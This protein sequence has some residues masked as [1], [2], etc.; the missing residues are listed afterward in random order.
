MAQPPAPVVL[1]GHICLWNGCHSTFSSLEELISHVNTSHLRAYSSL[2]EPVLAPSS[3][4]RLSSDVLGLS[5][6]WDNCHEYSSTPV[7]S[8]VNLALDDALNSLTG[9]LLHDHLGL[10]GGPEDHSVMSTN[11]AA[12]ADVAL[13]VPSPNPGQDVEMRDEEQCS[14]NKQQI[15]PSG[16]SSK[17]D[18]T[19]KQTDEQRRSTIAEDKPLTPEIGGSRKCCW[20]ECE[21]SFAS[22]DDLMN[23]L[24]GEHVGAGKNHYECFW[25]DCERNGEKGFSSKQKVCR[26]LQVR[27]S[28]RR[29]VSR[30][31]F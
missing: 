26:H 14:D 27:V 28:P 4:L 31:L 20:R 30:P 23:H 25:G 11:Q 18:D 19:N 21:C 22:V 3:Y 2:P 10:Q 5:C 29:Y 16:G 6:Q 15:I 8:S 7:D 17:Q 13:P 9:H 1:P 24:T 12:L